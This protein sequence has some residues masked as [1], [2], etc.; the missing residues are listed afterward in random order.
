MGIKTVVNALT[1]IVLEGSK[2]NPVPDAYA[3][4]FLKEIF[5]PIVFPTSFE[6]MIDYDFIRDRIEA[7]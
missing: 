6:L 1:K 7:F 4:F 5:P 2:Y 3:D